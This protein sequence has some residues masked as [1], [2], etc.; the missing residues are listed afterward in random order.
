[1]L[2]F[3]ELVKE[4]RRKGNLKNMENRNKVSLLNILKKNKI[5]IMKKTIVDFLKIANITEEKLREK[6]IKIRKEF[7]GLKK[8]RNYCY[9]TIKE[10]EEELNFKKNYY[11]EFEE[12]I[13]L[14]TKE[15]R[16]QMFQFF[17][18]KIETY[19]YE[20]IEKTGL[21]DI[22][23]KIEKEIKLNVEKENFLFA[24]QNLRFQR[25]KILILLR[26]EEKEYN[27]FISGELEL[28]QYQKEK[29]INFLKEKID[30]KLDN[31]ISKTSEKYLEIL[32]EEI[33]R[34]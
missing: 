16:E 15:E 1:M 33:S 17:H 13:R 18:I 14:I 9:T 4:E 23:E 25:Q 12:G 2:E 27:Q 10:I 22:I 30:Y 19:K 20:K 31:K 8:I 3:K 5:F 32:N 26:M 21:H 24:K 7:A 29:L 34:E 6:N 28:T 11:K